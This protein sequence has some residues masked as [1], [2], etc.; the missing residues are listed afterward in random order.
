MLVILARDPVAPPLE[1]SLGEE[2]KTEVVVVYLVWKRFCAIAE[3]GSSS[4]LDE[5]RTI[6]TIL[7]IGVVERVDVD[8]RSASMLRELCSAGNCSIAE[9]RRVVAH[10]PS[11]S[12][13]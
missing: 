4:R 8:S 9:T 3:L 1:A 5:T 2:T 11:S 7:V 12:A 10:L 13:S 6:G